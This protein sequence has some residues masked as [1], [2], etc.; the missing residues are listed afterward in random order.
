[1]VARGPESISWYSTDEHQ[2]LQ[3]AG[4][5]ILIRLR[6]AGSL[7]LAAE[8]ALGLSV[9]AVGVIATINTEAGG[10]EK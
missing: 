10:Q 6:V 8:R 1:M 7:W 2:A 5:L 3:N 4:Y 9:A